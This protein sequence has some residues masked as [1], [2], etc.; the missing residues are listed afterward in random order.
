MT[1]SSVL[2]LALLVSVVIGSTAAILAWRAIPRPG[3]RWLA[4]LLVGQVWWSLSTFYRLRTPGIEGKTFWLM[5][6]WIGVVLI[7]LAWVLFALEYSGRDLHLGYR[8]IGALGVIPVLTL[9]FVLTAPSH[10]LI[11]IEF[12]GYTDTGIFRVEF[13]GLWYWIIAVYTYLLGAIGLLLLFDLLASQA[14][15]FKEQGIALSLGL[16][17]PW[18]TNIL[19][20]LGVFDLGF[21]PTPIAFAPSGVIYLLAIRRFDLLRANP[22]PTKRARQMVFDGVQEGAIIV[23]MD[24]HVIDMN[25]RAAGILEASRRDALGRYCGEIVPGYEDLPETGALEDYLTIETGGR[26]RQFEVNVQP[27]TTATDRP[28]GRLV[29][30]NEVTALLRQQQR[31]EVLHRVLRHNIRTETNL[32]LGYSETVDGSAGE[33]IQSSAR[34]IEALGEKGREAIDLFSKSR[35]ETQAHQLDTMLEDAIAEV[36]A[37]VPGV[38]V[39]YEYTGLSVAVDGLLNAVFRN[40]IENAAVHNPDPD[41][42]VWIE[43]SASQERVTVEVRDDGPGIGDHELRVLSAGTETQLEH[44]SGI[45]L[46]IIMWGADLVDGQVEFAER[47]PTGTTVTI[48]VPVLSVVTGD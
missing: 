9:V 30:I 8:T 44:G 32:I 14:L 23:D 15:L 10:S 37:T 16:L 33:A 26:D 36:E 21:D 20:V 27:I 7:P 48:E 6:M 12:V 17:F 28:I 4:V 13:G 5:V 1:P 2:L 24:G 19:F 34:T 40:T 41:P 31:L 42:T 18:L 3:S 47:E 43:V 39:Q 45:G 22:A 46:W 35:A 25:G 29:T 38:S 11:T